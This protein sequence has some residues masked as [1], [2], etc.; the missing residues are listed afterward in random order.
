MQQLL[1]A[2]ESERVLILRQGTRS[3]VVAEGIVY[4]VR[5]LDVFARC[6]FKRYG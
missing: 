2:R 3:S 5:L 4:Y 6:V 1:R